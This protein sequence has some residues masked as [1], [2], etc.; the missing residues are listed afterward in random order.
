MPEKVQKVKLLLNMN[1]MERNQWKL[2][3]LTKMATTTMV[4]PEVG[5]QTHSFTKI[6]ALM[7]ANR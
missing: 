1:K 2:L 4:V 3:F 6:I 7:K 5:L